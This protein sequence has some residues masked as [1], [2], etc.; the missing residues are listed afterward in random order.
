[1]KHL[2]VQLHDICRMSW[3]TNAME[4]V[5]GTQAD[6]ID[7][8]SAR[9]ISGLGDGKRV[10]WLI[11]G[12]SNILL[13][14]EIMAAVRESG[15]DLAGLAVMP[16]DERYGEAGHKDSNIQQLRDAGFESGE[17]TLVDILIHNVPF[18]QTV[19]F[20]ND[21][22][23]TAFASAGVVIGQFGLGADGHV[24]GILPDSPATSAEPVVVIGYE[25]SDYIRLTLSAEMLKQIAVAF[26]PAFGAGKADALARLREDKEKF[27][28][29][30][31][32]LLYDLPEVHVY[33]DHLK[34]E[35]Q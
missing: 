22:A 7:A 11:S 23:S 20:Y 4:F 27:E 13:E 35:E 15:A 1:M 6:A 10:L 31:A 19:S 2:T 21:I 25:W 9:I 29:L 16:M 17:A 32:K 8:V 28:K 30:P 24:A 3:Y 12:G 5:E 33:T 34:Q 14:V 26:V 18:D